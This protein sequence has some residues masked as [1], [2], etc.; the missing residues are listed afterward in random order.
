MAPVFWLVPVWGLVLGG[1]RCP[2]VFVVVHQAVV[3][4]VFACIGTVRNFSPFQVRT[5]AAVHGS[6]CQCM[7]NPLQQLLGSLYEF[8]GAPPPPGTTTNQEPSTPGNRHISLCAGHI[9]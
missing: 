2:G 1:W 3:R 7:V 6:A 9:L 8:S 4:I 5:C